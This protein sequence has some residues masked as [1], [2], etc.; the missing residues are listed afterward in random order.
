MITKGMKLVGG[1]LFVEGSL[2]IAVSQ[3]QKVLSNIGRLGKIAFDHSAG[4]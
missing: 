3:D 4:K 1:S 2:S